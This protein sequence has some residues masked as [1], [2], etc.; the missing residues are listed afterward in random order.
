MTYMAYTVLV[1]GCPKPV[2]GTNYREYFEWNLQSIQ[3]GRRDGNPVHVFLH[4]LLE[5][6]YG[7]RH[8]VKNEGARLRAKYGRLFDDHPYIN[9]TFEQRTRTCAS[10]ARTARYPLKGPSSSSRVW[11]PSRGPLVL[12][13]THSLR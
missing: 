3:D 7:K 11:A 13:G 2:N 8:A 1:H 4:A 10:N 12:H 6:K 9:D 5:S